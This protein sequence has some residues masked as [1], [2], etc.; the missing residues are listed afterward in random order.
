MARSRFLALVAAALLTT[1]AAAGGTPR[2]IPIPDDFA[3]EGVAVGSRSTFYVGSLWDGDIY[4]GSLRTGEGGLLVDTDG[5]QAAGLKVEVRR[6]RLWVA[7]GATGGGT[8]YDTRDGAVVA[9]FSFG[10]PM[11]TLVNDVVVTQRA[12]YFTDSISPVLY[13]VP[14]SPNGEIGTPQ[15]LALTGPA[16]APS[17]F[18]G[19][20]GIDATPSGDRLV[21]GHTL[22]GAVYL[23]DPQTGAS[24][25]IDLPPRA[26]PTSDGLLLEGRTLWVVNNFINE[27]AEVRLAPDLLS[28]ELVRVIDNV[29]ADGL[30]RIPTTVA[31]HGDN[32]VIVNG[33]FDVGLP[34]PFGPGAPAGTDY[35]VVVLDAH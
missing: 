20:N 27:I 16:A 6:H 19:L 22:F 35:D 17:A 33:R 13:V 31:R 1:A 24:Q 18:P 23:V 21:V 30:L 7:G 26:A 15:T 14:L 9:T 2:S 8:V 25:L 4:Q 29:A 10:P 28:G 11:Q 3:P 12:A 32:L 34:P 5:G